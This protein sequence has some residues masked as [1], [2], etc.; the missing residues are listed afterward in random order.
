MQSAESLKIRL[1]CLIRLVLRVCVIS[2]N[3]KLLFCWN[4]AINAPVKCQSSDLFI[5]TFSTAIKCHKWRL[6]RAV[7]MRELAATIEIENEIS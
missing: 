7:K 6:M 5:S 2:L 3:L 4:F 1:T